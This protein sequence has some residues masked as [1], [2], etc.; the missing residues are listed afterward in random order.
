MPSSSTRRRLG[1]T[2]AVAFATLVVSWLLA[3]IAVLRC[4]SIGVDGPACSLNY[5]DDKAPL[6]VLVLLTPA[7]L[8]AV[9]SWT[10]PTRWGLA[11]TIGI[12]VA[13]IEFGLFLP[14]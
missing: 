7:L 6:G 14:R 11:L 13:A 4:E 8:A 10:R 2:A 3:G 12:A 1:R 9:A 5:D